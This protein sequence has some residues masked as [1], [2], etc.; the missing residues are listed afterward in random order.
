[1]QSRENKATFV[2]V[3]T[4]NFPFP[5]RKRNDQVER[6]EPQAVHV[7]HGDIGLFGHL[8]TGSSRHWVE[9]TMVWAD[10]ATEGRE[11]GILQASVAGIWGCGCRPRG[12]ASV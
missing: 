10:E 3:L 4:G 1:M 8:K 12:M 9:Q 11:L 6:L 2:T 7:T 5:D